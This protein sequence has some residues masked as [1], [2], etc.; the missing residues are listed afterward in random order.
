MERMDGYVAVTLGGKW[1]TIAQ[2]LGMTTEEGDIIKDCFQ[3]F[4]DMAVVYYETA[5]VKWTQDKSSYEEGGDS[6]TAQE[7]PGGLWNE[8]AQ[9]QA[10]RLGVKNNGRMEEATSSSND[11]NVIV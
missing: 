1:G 7:N 5:Q 10:N 6:W 2:T 8:H 4:V 9:P 11:F 3:K